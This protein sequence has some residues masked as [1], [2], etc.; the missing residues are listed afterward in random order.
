V[1]VWFKHF[2]GLI[3]Y[4][5]HNPFTPNCTLKQHKQQLATYHNETRHTTSI[6]VFLKQSF[7]FVSCPKMSLHI[8]V[9][10]FWLYVT[11]LTSLL[12][13]L[14]LSS[15]AHTMFKIQDDSKWWTQLNSKRRLNTRQA[16]RCAI[17]SSLLAIQ[18]DLRG[19]RSK[20]SW[21]R[22]TFSSDTRKNLG[23]IVVIFL[24]TDTAPWLYA[25][26]A[27]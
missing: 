6:A 10:T 20:L 22:L 24:S 9:C 11:G 15:H 14:W 5:K 13:L 27:R 8:W 18:F 23:C 2:L 19:L 7:L 4:K 16:V 17:P 21:I 12:S 1:S 25:R 26:R 3:E